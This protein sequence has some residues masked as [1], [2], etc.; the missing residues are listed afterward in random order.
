VKFCISSHPTLVYTWQKLQKSEVLVA[1]GELFQ[2]WL[3]WHGMTQWV[4][5]RVVAGYYHQLTTI[6]SVSRNWQQ[7]QFLRDW[8]RHTC[9]VSLQQLLTYEQKA[10]LPFLSFIV[11]WLWTQR[12]VRLSTIGAEASYSVVQCACYPRCMQISLWMGGVWLCQRQ[13]CIV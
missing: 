12:L 10:V 7:F 5:S 11:E 9:R 3:I 8:I 2:Y 6:T 1:P 4:Y 13:V